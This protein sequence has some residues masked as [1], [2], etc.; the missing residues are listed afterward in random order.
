MMAMR[1]CG[2]T[3]AVMSYRPTA[4]LVYAVDGCRRHPGKEAVAGR[5]V[6]IAKNS[7]RTVALIL[8]AALAVFLW[9]GYD[10]TR[11]PGIL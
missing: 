9:N 6:Q 3:I 5:A 7:Q 2:M 8:D 1:G 10:W 11:I 4:C